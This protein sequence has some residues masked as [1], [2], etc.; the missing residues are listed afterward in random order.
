MMESGNFSR[1][2]QAESKDELGELTLSMNQMAL[3]LSQ[4]VGHVVRS[5][6][7]LYG[8]RAQCGGR[9]NRRAIL[10]QQKILTKSP[11]R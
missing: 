5:R 6:N 11:P 2:L 9:N 7:R 3:T 4:T 10:C 1:V 8:D